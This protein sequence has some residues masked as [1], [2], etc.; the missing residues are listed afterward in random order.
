MSRKKYIRKLFFNYLPNGAGTIG[1]KNYCLF[2]LYSL[3][4]IRKIIMN[5]SLSDIDKKMGKSK[6]STQIFK[7]NGNIFAFDYKF[8]DS[9][10]NETSYG[11]SLAREIYLKNC[12]LKHLPK[13][14]IN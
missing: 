10:L 5:K 9:M 14:I 4:N 3:C 12:Y 6:F 7:I 1:I 2:M 13:K 8:C 11:Y